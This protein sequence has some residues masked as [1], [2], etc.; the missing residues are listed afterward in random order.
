MQKKNIII[1]TI[2]IIGIII[3]GAFFKIKFA[4]KSTTIGTTSVSNENK[5]IVDTKENNKVKIVDENSKTRPYAIVVNNTPVAVKVQTGLN[6][7][8]LIYE[9]P[10]EGNTSRLMALYK[11]ID[12]DFTIGTIRSSRHDFIDYAL[13][14]NAIFIH[15]GWSHYAEEDQK[16]GVIDYING[17][18]GGPFWRDNPE[19]LAS[20][21]TAYTSINKLKKEIESKGFKTTGDNTLLLNY[22]AENINL[23]EKENSIKANKVVIP[24]GS[25]KNTTTFV[26]NET[27][28]MYDRQENG[29]NCIDHETKEQVSTKNIIVQKINY[30]VCD[31]NYYWNLQTVGSG[32]G[33]YITNGQAVPITWSK[34]DRSSQTKYYYEDGTEIELNDGRTY[35]ELQTNSQKTTIQ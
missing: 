16:K 34:K 9:I 17:L 8:Y 20:E 10:T 13:E 28:K 22:S 14:S 11:D 21:H 35:I 1:I 18:Y 30:K 26:Y 6:K 25:T 23:S 31:D 2:I 29:N 15:Y 27:T 33:Y 24:Y 19:K 32:K 12:E 3:A 5:L 7:A 4:Q